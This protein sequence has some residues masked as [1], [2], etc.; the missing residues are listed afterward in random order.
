M[1]LVKKENKCFISKECRLISANWTCVL[2]DGLQSFASSHGNW[3]CSCLRPLCQCMCVCAKEWVSAS[4]EREKEKERWFH[5]DYSLNNTKQEL[6]LVEKQDVARLSQFIFPECIELPSSPCCG[7]WY[8]EWWNTS[9]WHN[10]KSCSVLRFSSLGLAVFSVK[11]FR[12]CHK[13]FNRT[14]VWSFSSYSWSVFFL[15]VNTIR[16]D[17][18]HFGYDQTV[19]MEKKYCKYQKYPLWAGK[20]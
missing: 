3:A 18:C 12:R 4:K 9:D 13:C 1:L 16:S 2:I 19:F 17:L 5:Y 20:R 7:F 15:C 14:A 11:V 6:A 8:L 10:V